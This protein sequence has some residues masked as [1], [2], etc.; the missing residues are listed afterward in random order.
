MYTGFT[1]I[2]SV[3]FKTVAQGNGPGSMLSVYDS[4]Y[5]NVTSTLLENVLPPLSNLRFECIYFLKPYLFVVNLAF[6]V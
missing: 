3:I 2:K 1:A 5:A 4:R 6:K